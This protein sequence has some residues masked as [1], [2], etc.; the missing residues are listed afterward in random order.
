[1]HS[2]KIGTEEFDIPGFLMLYRGI[3]EREII[4]FIA[5]HEAEKRVMR[6]GRKT[7]S[8]R[9]GEGLSTCRNPKA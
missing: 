6:V 9:K 7:E 1:M 4:M 5:Q 8:L 2:S 3:L